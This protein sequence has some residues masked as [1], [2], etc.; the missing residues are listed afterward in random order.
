MGKGGR[1][2]TIT[3]MKKYELLQEDGLTD[4]IIMERGRVVEQGF[5]LIGALLQ[6]AMSCALYRRPLSEYAQGAM[7]RKYLKG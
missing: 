1:N 7:M 4:A 5:V 3:T 6:Y 2:E